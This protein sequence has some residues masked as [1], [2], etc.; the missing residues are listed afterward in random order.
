MREV[1]LSTETHAQGGKVVTSSITALVTSMVTGVT[2]YRGTS[3]I[4]TLL[5]CATERRAA[6]NITLIIKFI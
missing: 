2:C 4:L 6:T 3:L 5:R 1:P